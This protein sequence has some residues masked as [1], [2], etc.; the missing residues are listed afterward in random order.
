MGRF[1][2]ALG[3]FL[4]TAHLGQGGRRRHAKHVDRSPYL[5]ALRLER[6]EERALLDATPTGTSYMLYENWGG[7][8]CD[9][10]K[11]TQAGDDLMCWA[12]AASNVLEWTGWGHVGGMTNADH[13]FQYFQ[14]HWTDAG[15]LARY[16]WN[17]WFDG[18]N[19]GSVGSNWSQVDV[20]GG[21]FYPDLPPDNYIHTRGQGG[22]AQAYAMIDVDQYCRGLTGV[23]LALFGTLDHAVTCWGFNYDPAL[24]PSDRAYYKGVWISDSDDDAYTSDGATAPDTLHYHTVAWDA[25]S[26]RYYVDSYWTGAYIGEV[27]GLEYNPNWAAADRFE[28]NDSFAAAT[29]LGAVEDRTENN[30][31][32]HA[33]DNDDYFKLTAVSSGTLN[34]DITFA[35]NLGDLDLYL[36]DSSQTLVDSSNGVGDTEHVSYSVSAGQDY[37]IKVHGHN[38]DIHRNYNLVIDA[39]N[40]PVD[41]FEPNDSRAA[42]A[43]LG[44][45]VDWTENNLSIH[46]AYNRDYYMFTPSHSG[47]LTVDINFNHSLGNLDLALYNSQGFGP[48]STGYGDNEHVSYSVTAGQMYYIEVIGYS[49]ATNSNYSLVIDGPNISPD[50]LE[51]NNSLADAADLG[52]LGDWTQENLSIH[53]SDNDDYY[54]LTTLTSGTLNV[55]INFDHYSG[56][57]NLYLYDASYAIVAVSIGYGDNEHVSYAVSVGQVYYVEV[58][59]WGGQTNPNY[60]L[61]IDGPTIPADRFEPN[62]F[63]ATAT[64]FGTLIDRTEDN[65]TIHAAYN[66]DYYKFNLNAAASGALNVDINFDH[67]EGNLDLYLYDSSHALVASSI[68]Y[69]DNEHIS[70]SVSPGQDYYIK[71]HGNGGAASPNY[72]LVIDG[73]NVPADRF[74]PN[75]N[76][77]AATNLGTLGDRTEDNLSIH[78]AWNADW[79]KLNAAASGTLNADISF[80]HS[81]GNLDLDLYNSSG[82]LLASSTGAGN[83]EH[84]SYAVTAGQVYYI[85]VYGAVG[86]LNPNYSLVIDGPNIPADRFEPNDSLEDAT[87]FGK[88]GDRTE[89]NLSIHAAYSD[90][91]YKLT[92]EAS[93]TLNVDINFTHSLGDLNLYLYDSSQAL[94]ATS[95]G[96]DDNEHVA[97]AVT[98]GQV[99]YIEVQ[100]DSGA[101]NPNYS[102]VIDGPNIPADRFEPND[103]FDAA[104]NFGT[105]G[106]LTADSLSIH[107]AHNDDYFRLT[108]ESF[109]TLSVDIDFTHSLGDLDLYLYDSSRTQVASSIGAADNEHVSH[110]ATAGQVYYIKVQ[111]HDG[112][113]NPNYTLAIHD[114]AYVFPDRF[115]SNDTFSAAADLGTLGDR[116]EN[117]LTIHLANN[118]DFYKLTAA[119]SGTLNVDI[120]FTHSQGDL[121]LYLYDSSQ[122]QAA[123][124]TGVGNNEHVSY[125]VTAGQVYYIKVIGYNGAT[126]P[127]YTLV[128]DSPNGLLDRFEPNDSFAAATDFGWLGDRTENSLSIHA[129][130]NDDYYKFTPVSSGTLNVDIDFYNYQGDLD[131][132]LYNSSQTQVASS[133]GAA[134]NE[135]V[136]Y[137]VAAGLAYYIKVQG[138]NGAINPD[139]SLAIDAPYGGADRFEPNDSFAAAADLGTL[140]DRT[141]EHLSV[142]SFHGVSNNDYYKLTAAASGTLDV[143]INFTHFLG[144]LDLYL[145]NSSQTPV[146]SSTEVGD[147]EEIFYSV[148]A[149][150]IYY[151]KVIGYNG[152]TNPNYSLVIDGPNVLGD[153][154]GDGVVDDRDASILGA[155]WRMAEGATWAM[156][157]FNG[158]GKV[159]DKDAAIMA[160]HWTEQTPEAAELPTSSP[161]LSDGPVHTPLMGPRPAS[162]VPATRRRLS[163]PREAARA[164]VFAE[165]SAYNPSR[166][167]RQ[168]AAWSYEVARQTARQRLTAPA[169]RV[170]ARAAIDLLMS[171]VE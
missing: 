141:E 42:A 115:E 97:Y 22:T 84:V 123:S 8:W 94:V 53:E 41:R 112:A 139:Y 7:T 77:A 62:G 117:S 47:T 30:L 95:T 54:K 167:Q 153:A 147:N 39:P 72:S 169:D 76:Y 2:A 146:A 150:Q 124:S 35:H 127:N 50:F 79:Y 46:A 89:D 6:F 105:L 101:I 58:H 110:E 16:G 121:N 61:V 155:H 17:W 130:Y 13:M 45:L 28:P 102:L 151:I 80:T 82:A 116:T 66:D 99:Y 38:G 33:A 88:L 119:S 21:D 103:G 166:E 70:Y 162:A 14:N 111:G 63:F 107:A 104:I 65:L 81:L 118:D 29:S 137:G 19:D 128:I 148:T 87:D 31:S 93:G 43:D 114:T 96:A 75:D 5:R 164:A 36:Y 10:E 109:G 145:Y 23:T 44:T 74:E 108:T 60:S 32:I 68:G 3:S 149:G 12:A 83:N 24:S 129:A 132:Y 1:S 156:G 113:T 55:D 152:A 133:I 69:G 159:N 86:A 170:A 9:A 37:Y 40:M 125:A 67:N 157:D 90:D 56:N 120:N 15:G 48:T 138:R 100:G 168:A 154:N 106:D 85:E 4:A 27:D 126:S 18:T 131:L 135:H 64:D 136:S 49:G 71:V 165:A 122:T 142:H 52:T 144:N 34:A 78:A 26:N 98:A 25:D 140:G 161:Q 20:P 134:D 158:D 73:P 51:P 160:A 92:T 57:L 91:Y 59:G 11:D 143:N 171:A 163:D